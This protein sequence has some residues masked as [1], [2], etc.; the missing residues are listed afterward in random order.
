MHRKKT[1][2]LLEKKTTGT[3]VKSTWWVGYAPVLLFACVCCMR[4]ATIIPLVD[5]VEYCFTHNSNV[6]L[7]V[8]TGTTPQTATTGSTHLRHATSQAL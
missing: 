6:S 8:A 2:Y 1:R 4:N 5:S 7:V 3:A